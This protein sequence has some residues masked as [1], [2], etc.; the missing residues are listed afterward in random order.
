MPKPVLAWLVDAGDF[1][2]RIKSLPDAPSWAELVALANLRL[3]FLRTDR[4]DTVLRRCFP[5]PPPGLATQ[6][7]R[8]AILGSSTTVHLAAPIRVAAL[9]RNIHVVIQEGEY[10]QYLQELSDVE[11]ELHRF[12]PHIVLLALDSRHVTA[13]IEDDA[14]LDSMR[15]RIA[16][17]W[18]MAR[19]TLGATVIQQA[20]LPVLPTLL[21]SNEHRLPGSPAR[22]IA[23]LN[24]ALR[25]DADAA[26]VHLL[27]V[28]EAASRDGILEWHDPVL[29]H[30]S[31]Q[32]ISPVAAPLYGD[33]VGRLIAA[34]QG[35]AAKCLVLDLDNTLW[36]G[37]IG[38]DG[39]EGIA[40]GQGSALGEAH[41]AVQAY[42]QALARR[43]VILAVCSKNDEANARAAFERHPDML[44]RLDDISCFVANWDDKATNLRRIAA[45]LNIGTDNLVFLDDNPFERNLVRAALPEVAVPE[46][47]DDEPALMPDV[48]AAAGYFE[49]VAIT[50][51]DRARIAHYAANT[52]RAALEASTTDMPAYLRS[53]EMRLVWR[54]FNRIGLGRIVQLINKT[55]QFNLTTRRL[56]E[57]QVLAVMADANAFGLQ[58]R[59]LDR[60]GDNGI[61]A[62]VIG[63]IDADGDCLIDTWLMSCRVLGRSVEA[64]TLALVAEQARRLGAASL[65][66]EYRPTA[67]NAMVAGHYERLGFTR[68]AEFEDGGHRA[69][70][71]LAGF[72]AQDSAITVVQGD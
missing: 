33:L 68:I 17:C 58:L 48:L 26:G 15:A 34:L 59:L 14:G 45:S 72:T 2:G 62:I 18:Q 55:N 3:D 9:R 57:E 40:I 49:A 50:D 16:R 43:G 10:G 46:V 13:G 60:F 11:S 4:L 21:G 35:R 51:E 28:D 71:A 66:G 20:I 25:D 7:V 69:R 31:K 52:A 23:R 61:I 70:L 65:L 36:G 29:W 44:L 54:R 32:E 63:R 38:D 64:A 53:L 27:A 12:C 42:A 56:T 1:N 30:R 47:P 39:L 37:V 8:L 5:T 67:K 41:L 24:G 19:E 6:P 22:L